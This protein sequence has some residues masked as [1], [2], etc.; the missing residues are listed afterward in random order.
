MDQKLVTNV[1]KQVY[2]RFPEVD[3]KKPKVRRQ[4]TPK[5]KDLD[6]NPTYLLT[7]RSKAQVQ[8]GKT[9]QRY[10]RV[11]VDDRGKIIKITTSR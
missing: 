6:S 4:A 5:V 1:S 11:V 9:I 3:G 2:R 10:I 8:G 7:Y